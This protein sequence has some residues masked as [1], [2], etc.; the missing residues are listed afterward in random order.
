M[1][2]VKNFTEGNRKV[3]NFKKLYQVGRICNDYM[4]AMFQLQWQIFWFVVIIKCKFTSISVKS[5]IVLQQLHLKT[6]IFLLPHHKPNP[7]THKFSIINN[8]KASTFTKTDSILV[9]NTDQK[10]YLEINVE[11]RTSDASDSTA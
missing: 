3:K 4:E 11:S 7:K 2:Q 8:K 6:R 9:R 5:H 10:S 1:S